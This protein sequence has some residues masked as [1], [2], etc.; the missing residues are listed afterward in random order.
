MLTG[1]KF[2]PLPGLC[3]EIAGW[4]GLPPQTDISL[5]DM[6]LHS[7]IAARDMVILL[8][9]ARQKGSIRYDPIACLSGLGI[10]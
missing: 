3:P 2:N 10:R 7:V 4:D 1:R 6:G 8:R 9:S 5:V